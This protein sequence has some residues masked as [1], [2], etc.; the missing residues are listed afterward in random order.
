MPDKTLYRLDARREAAQ[1]VNLMT[2][3][4]TLKKLQ[5]LIHADEHLAGSTGMVGLGNT[6]YAMLKKMELLLISKIEQGPLY[7][8]LAEDGAYIIVFDD[9]DRDNEMF[10]GQSALLCALRRFAQISGSWNA[11]LYA[12][13]KS[14]TRDDQ[15]GDMSA[16]VNPA[17]AEREALRQ[18]VSVLKERHHGR[19]PEQVEQAYVNAIDVLEASKP[20]VAYAMVLDSRDRQ[21]D[22]YVQSRKN[23]EAEAELQGLEGEE[24]KIAALKHAFQSGF[25]AAT[26]SFVRIPWGNS[27]RADFNPIVEHKE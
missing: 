4:E 7:G 22:E 24:W 8:Q 26:N 13:F 6:S 3:A 1:R 15:A 2:D 25:N 20:N 10:S 17:T 14:N 5:E 21:A 18:L 9:A 12:K 11:Q 19:M 23:V 16:V 27:D